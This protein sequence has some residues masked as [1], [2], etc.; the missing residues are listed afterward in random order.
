MT[1]AESVDDPR[2][3]SI[4]TGFSR[5]AKDPGQSTTNDTAK[6]IGDIG[7]SSKSVGCV[8]VV[9]GT[10]HLQHPMVSH[11]GSHSFSILNGFWL[12]MQHLE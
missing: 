11:L 10:E 4:A 7:T 9:D 8:T 3:S 12:L 5:M 2:T 1:P 6:G